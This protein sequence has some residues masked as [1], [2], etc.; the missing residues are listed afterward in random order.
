M[1]DGN[2]PSQMGLLGFGCLGVIGIALLMY[3]MWT[4]GDDADAAPLT[5][6]IAA[7]R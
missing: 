7:E 5:P 4:S 1:A 2:G 6:S 3:L